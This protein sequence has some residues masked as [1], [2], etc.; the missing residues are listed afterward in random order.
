MRKNLEIPQGKRTKLYRFLEVQLDQIE[1]LLLE[2]CCRYVFECRSMEGLM[3]SAQKFLSLSQIQNFL[4]EARR[5]F[6]P[7]NC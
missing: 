6:R 7:T 2:K 5:M 3:L 1:E 4:I